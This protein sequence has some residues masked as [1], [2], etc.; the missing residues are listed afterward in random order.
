MMPKFVSVNNTD[1]T[2]DDYTFGR[3]E[4]CDYCFEEHGGMSNPQYRTF[5]NTHFRIYKVGVDVTLL[6]VYV[7]FSRSLTN[8]TTT[9][10]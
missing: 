9:S 5:S 1:M 8:Q 4:L 3:A 10:I 6:I 2:D 7:M